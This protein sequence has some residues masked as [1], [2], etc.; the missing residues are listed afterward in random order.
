MNPS[1]GCDVALHRHGR[2]HCKVTMNDCRF[3]LI[4]K[5]MYKP[6]LYQDGSLRQHLQ[7]AQHIYGGAD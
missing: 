5:I 3:T 4:Q 2:S 7:R 6:F 1:C